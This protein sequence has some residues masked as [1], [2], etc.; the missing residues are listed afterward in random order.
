[1][2]N[3]EK[4]SRSI[5]KVDDKGKIIIPKKYAKDLGGREKATLR[6]S[7]H[8]GELQLMS[9]DAFEELATALNSIAKALRAEGKLSW[10]QERRLKRD[11]F[12]N[13]Y[14]VSFDGQNR[15]T[16]PKYMI[17]KFNLSDDRKVRITE[18]EGEIFKILIQNVNSDDSN[19]DK[20]D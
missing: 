15:I 10:E 13:S 19:S 3:I 7:T 6:Y 8:K 17:K 4:T 9:P 1:M 5:V 14:G 11:F 18:N 20:V 12:S 2:K 16:I